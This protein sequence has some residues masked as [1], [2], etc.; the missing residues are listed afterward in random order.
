MLNRYLQRIYDSIVSRGH[1]GI[2]RLS[3]DELPGRQGAIEGRLTFHDGSMLEFYE[4][5]LMRDGQLA[6]LR[7]AYH[8]Q[9]AAGEVIF[10]YDNAPHHPH[11]PTH[12]HHKHIGATAVVPASAPDLGEVL[13]EIEH[14]IFAPD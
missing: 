3:F 11:I 12:P 10:R 2:E 13:R 8:F 5:L 4:V 7:Y 9:N 14:L 6:K 1:V